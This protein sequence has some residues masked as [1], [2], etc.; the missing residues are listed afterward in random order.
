MA[1]RETRFEDTCEITGV[2]NDISVLGEILSFQQN[3]VIIATINRSAKVTLRW[4]NHA[5]LYIGSLGGV[6]FTSPGPKSHTYRTH[7]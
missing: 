1:A 3:D 6:E 2:K 5:T 4:K 7:R